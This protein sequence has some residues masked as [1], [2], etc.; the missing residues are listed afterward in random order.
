MN[1]LCR[2]SIRS[3]IKFVDAVRITNPVM[4]EQCLQYQSILMQQ[5]APKDFTFLFM[6]MGG[7][8]PE[9]ES[10]IFNEGLPCGNV[11]LDCLGDSR[12]GVYLSTSMDACTVSPLMPFVPHR[13]IIF[14]VLLG[15]IRNLP[16]HDF[17]DPPKVEYEKGVHSHT[18]R[19]TKLHGLP[20]YN[21][22]NSLVYMFDKVDDYTF[23]E[24]PRSIYPYAAVTLYLNNF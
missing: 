5:R 20:H 12:Y 16:F 13:F 11:P 19:A 3:H 1:N 2:D 10:R 15:N 24:Y 14:K 18:T 9:R 21:F 7:F 6:D 17:S 8:D 4:H 23:N 22:Y